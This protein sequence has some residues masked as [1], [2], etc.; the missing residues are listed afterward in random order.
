MARQSILVVDDEVIWH[1]LLGRVLRESSYEVRAAATCAE[2]VKL[3]ALH[4]PDCIILDFHL[5]DGDAVAVCSA[6]KADKK[7][8]R[9]PVIIFSS[10]PAAEITAYSECKADYFLLKGPGAITDLPLVV[11]RVLSPAIP[12][13]LIVEI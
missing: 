2:G 1:R 13:N 6:L 11:E 10:D 5:T 12:R 7:T 4:N 3:A 9:I 8:A